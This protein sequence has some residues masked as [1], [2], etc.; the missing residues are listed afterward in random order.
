MDA[1]DPDAFAV[2]LSSEE[3]VRGK[4]AAAARSRAQ[5]HER[6]WVTVLD[7]EVEITTSEG[8]SITGGS[9]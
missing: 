8:K 2:T 3:V 6:A 9:C 1:A 5:V 7:G 4:R